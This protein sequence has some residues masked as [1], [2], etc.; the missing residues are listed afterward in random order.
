MREGLPLQNVFS[1]IDL[2]Q[3]TDRAYTEAQELEREAEKASGVSPYQ[4]GQ[5]S[6][7]YNRTA[8]GV[9]LISEQG[10]TRF[11]FKTS[12]AEHTGYKHLVRQYAS[13]LQQYIPDELVIRI[14]ADRA[15][16]QAQ[17]IMMEQGQMAIAQG[18]DP[19]MVMMQQQALMQDPAQMLEVL[20]IDPFQGFKKVTP[21]G[22]TGRFDF[23]IDP[24]SSAQ[25]LSMRREQVMSLAQTGMQDPY[26]KPIPI[27]K[28]LVETFGFKDVD[29]YLRS[30]QEVQM[31]QMA[32]S[33]QAQE[34][35]GQEGE[36]A[37]E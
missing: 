21:E 6:P 33:Q 2:G 26:F 27:R 7:A 37:T 31:M 16:E 30:E 20:G 18:M 8:T 15:M 35:P 14:E 10:N 11:S 12:L 25:S 34:A 1:Q 36:G 13:L 3:V 23:K 5:D 24:E 19:N 32:A 4:T 22:I 29:T 17:K 9:A 28:K